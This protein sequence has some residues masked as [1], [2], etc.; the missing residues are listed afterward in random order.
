M[1]KI[2]EKAPEKVWV[3]FARD[4]KISNVQLEKFQAYEKLLSEWNQNINLTAIKDLSGIVRQHFVDSIVLRD[5]VDLNKTKLIVDIGSG[6]GFPGIPL[7]ILY[8]NLQ[9]ILIEVS[10][11]KQNFLEAV[12]DELE[13]E[14]IEVCG[15]DWRTFL[16]T[17]NAEVDFFITRAAI[18]EAELC[19]MFKPGCTYKNAGLIYWVTD[20]WQPNPKF[21]GL[22]KE[23][24][25][26]KLGKKRRRLAFFKLD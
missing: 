3:D 11:K 15:M 25:A 21:E 24:K 7:K 10:K 2:R 16:R 22:I 14:N 20:E 17:T 5:F 12:I 8:P 23:Y 18:D 4:Q 26:Y 1:K 19:R 6:A 9:V 13:L